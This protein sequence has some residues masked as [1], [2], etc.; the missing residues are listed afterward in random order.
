MGGGGGIRIKKM[1]FLYF[2]MALSTCILSFAIIFVSN[3]MAAENCIDSE[4]KGEDLAPPS[5]LLASHL[6]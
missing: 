4:E 6:H 2:R 3:T 5:F 1:E